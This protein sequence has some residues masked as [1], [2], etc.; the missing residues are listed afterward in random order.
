MFS[1]LFPHVPPKHIESGFLGTSPLSCTP[2]VRTENCPSLFFSC[3]SGNWGNLGEQEYAENILVAL[4]FKLWQNG[5]MKRIKAPGKTV[6]LPPSAEPMVKDLRAAMEAVSHIGGM[7]LNP[8]VRLSDGVVCAWGLA[9]ALV[10]MN[11]R[12]AIID[13]K[14]M[15][16]K[17]FEAV[18]KHIPEFVKRSEEEQRALFDLLFAGHCEFSA[19]NPDS[20]IK[21]A[22]S[23]GS[24]P[25]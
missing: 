15:Q 14:E 20:P 4:C 19:Y 7:K 3:L 17:L 6:R 18:V 23:E 24:A 22:Q 25:S 2:V 21:A 8:E 16:E 5:S 12:N 11:P 10:A 1:T 9:L 13:R